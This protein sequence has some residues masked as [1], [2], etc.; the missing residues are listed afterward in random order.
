MNQDA[1]DVNGFE[2]SHKKDSIREGS[3]T[4]FI[5]IM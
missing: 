4:Q 1:E 3:D 5:V 2:I